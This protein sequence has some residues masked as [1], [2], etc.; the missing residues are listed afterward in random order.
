M[1]LHNGPNFK[2]NEKKH[3]IFIFEFAFTQDYWP[4]LHI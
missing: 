2:Q 3:D 4:T 1:Q